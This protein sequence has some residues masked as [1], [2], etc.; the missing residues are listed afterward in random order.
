MK[1]P[2]IETSLLTMPF[3]RVG[4]FQFDHGILE[5]EQKPHP[6]G[7]PSWNRIGSKLSGSVLFVEFFMKLTFYETF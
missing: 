6:M 5:P 2:Y 7:I 3:L 4:A 1:V